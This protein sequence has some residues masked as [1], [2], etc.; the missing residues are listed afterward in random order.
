MSRTSVFFVTVIAAMVLAT[1]SQYM[2]YQ[3]VEPAQAAGQATA[4]LLMSWILVGLAYLLSGRRWTRETLAK[5]VIVASS[6]CAAL[7]TRGG[8]SH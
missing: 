8:L 1:I 3:H 7:A 5:A 4:F 6:I 2:I